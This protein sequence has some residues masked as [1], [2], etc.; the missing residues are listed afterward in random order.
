MK[1]ITKVI[2]G[3]KVVDSLHPA[4]FLVY[5]GLDDVDFWC[6]FDKVGKFNVVNVTG[7]CCCCLL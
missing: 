2:V 1:S 4:I 5:V 3:Y 7:V 6:S